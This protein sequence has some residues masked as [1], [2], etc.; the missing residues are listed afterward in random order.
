L[1][2]RKDTPFKAAA[3]CHPAMVDPADGPQ[4][5]I[6]IATLASGDE[7]KDAISKYESGLK[8][9]H[10]VKTYQDQIHGWMAARLVQNLASIIIA[11]RLSSNLED[12]E[13]KAAYE[14]GYK[15]LLDF[16]HEHL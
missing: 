15:T 2:S 7:D 10:I 8:V 14:D 5:A 6:P 16:Y 9:K 1:A 3:T 13:V 12:K 11:N 4:V